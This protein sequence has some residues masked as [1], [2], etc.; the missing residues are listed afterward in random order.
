MHLQ[1]PNRATQV[2]IC[3]WVFVVSY[4]LIGCLMSLIL[5]Q[6][7]PDRQRWVANI[8]FDILLSVVFVIYCKNVHVKA[9]SETCPMS[10]PC[11]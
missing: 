5:I 9:V 10:A 4:L 8:G 1:F 6:V 3:R 7:S 11:G 2:D